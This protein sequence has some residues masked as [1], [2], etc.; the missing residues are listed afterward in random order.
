MGVGEGGRVGDGVGVT[1]G[2][3]VG[4]GSSVGVVVLVGVLVGVMV[5]VFVGSSV[6]VGVDVGSSVGVGVGVSVG[7]LV[8]VIDGVI[9]GVGSIAGSMGDKEFCGSDAV[10]IAKSS[11]LL[12][13]STPLPARGS[14]SPGLRSILPSFGGLSTVALSLAVADPIPTKSTTVVPASL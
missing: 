5:G 11:L 2:V 13:E 6:G 7:V 12:S 9:L 14:L 10:R 4:V 1:V 8:G 3:F